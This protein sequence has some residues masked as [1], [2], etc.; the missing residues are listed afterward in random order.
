[1]DGWMDGEGIGRR[2][3]GGRKEG[4]RYDECVEESEREREKEGWCCL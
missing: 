3:G 1:M 4:M 2:R